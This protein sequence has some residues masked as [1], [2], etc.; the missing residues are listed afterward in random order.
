MTAQ[1]RG[2]RDRMYEIARRIE[3]RF[4]PI[5][6][7]LA[8]AP[9][10]DGSRIRDILDKALECKGLE[11]DEAAALATALRPDDAEALFAAAA[12]AEI[13]DIKI[14]I[15]TVMSRLSRGRERLRVVMEGRTTGANLRVVR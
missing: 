9:K 13:A 2:E 10:A 8:Q 11:L 15:G 14:P 7:I 12:T 3:A 5:D 1:P 4:E 6:G